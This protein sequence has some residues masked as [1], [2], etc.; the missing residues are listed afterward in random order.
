M[1]WYPKK[2]KLPVMVEETKHT[3][4]KCNVG[5]SKSDFK[6]NS[7]KICRVCYDTEAAFKARFNKRLDGATKR[8]LMRGNKK[9]FLTDTILAKMLDELKDCAMC[10]KPMKE[11]DDD[12]SMDRLD[13]RIGNEPYVFADGKINF[14]I[15]HQ[16][17]NFAKG[18]DDIK[19]RI[20]WR[21][22]EYVKKCHLLKKLS[23][24]KS[25]LANNIVGHSG[26]IRDVKSKIFGAG[27][28]EHLFFRAEGETCEN[29][30]TVCPKD[31]F[32]RYRHIEDGDFDYRSYYSKKCIDCTQFL[33]CRKRKNKY[34]NFRKENGILC[35]KCNVGVD[36]YGKDEGGLESLL[37]L[38]QTLEDPESESNPLLCVFDKQDN[39]YHRKC[40][41]KS[42]TH[43]NLVKNYW[44]AK[45]EYDRM[46]SNASEQV[47]EA[48]GYLLLQMQAIRDRFVTRY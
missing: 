8:T 29:C 13:S 12:W 16:T 5:K 45:Q 14:Q 36:V 33:R 26:I 23:E 10:K 1:P 7:C 20:I 18:E 32:K 22:G 34:P 40:H 38:E 15:T 47:K 11:T 48:S 2:R 4:R 6:F 41:P 35:S 3:C 28:K 39:A 42:W 43:H 37:S 24:D 46:W 9:E 44:K 25:V 17:C 19:E 27:E 31:D 30:A 21:T